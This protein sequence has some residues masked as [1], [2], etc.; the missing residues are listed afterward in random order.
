MIA[1]NNLTAGVAVSAGPQ[2][3]APFPAS[4]REKATPARFS[5][6]RWYLYAG[7][8]VCGRCVCTFI[9]KS[10]RSGPMRAGGGWVIRGGF[11]ATHV[12]GEM[13]GFCALFGSWVDGG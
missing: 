8:V 1:I 11:R 10:A 6:V 12:L 7:I 5:G 2:E 9:E 4:P 13:W 3:R